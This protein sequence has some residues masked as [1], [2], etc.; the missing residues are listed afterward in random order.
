MEPY[1]RRMFDE[2]KQLAERLDKLEIFIEGSI[3]QG[4]PLAKQTLLVAQCVTM[5][6]YLGILGQRIV[7]ETN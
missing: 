1:I 4:L 2:R 5:K 3:F 7:L 6:A